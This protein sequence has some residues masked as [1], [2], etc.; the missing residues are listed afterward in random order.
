MQAEWTAARNHY[1]AMA[2]LAI[3]LGAVVTL[4]DP[5]I[6]SAVALPLAFFTAQTAGTKF[7]GLAARHMT[8]AEALRLSA[9]AVAVQVGLGLAA[10]IVSLV[11]ER[12]QITAIHYDTI[13]MLGAA[14]VAITLLATLGGLRFG[15]LVELRRQARG[16]RGD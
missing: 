13:A 9:I 4:V 16:P 7:A 14:T 10:L 3:V 5:G 11:A 12:Q 15:S 1:L 8:G 2:A 6:G